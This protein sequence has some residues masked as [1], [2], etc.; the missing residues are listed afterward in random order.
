MK[1]LV[2]ATPTSNAL[3]NIE[4]ELERDPR[5]QSSHSR[6]GYLTDLR[7]FE[8]WRRNRPLTKLLV[9]EYAAHLQ[10]NKRSPNSINR[11][12]ASVRWWARRIADLA[13]DSALPRAQRDEIAGQAAR[14]ASVRD[15]SGQRLPKGRHVAPTELSALLQAC[16]QDAT[17]AG[18]R[19]AAL[20]TL[21]WSTG[22]RRSEICALATGDLKTIKG[23]SQLVVRGK[24]NKTRPAYLHAA[25]QSRLERWLAER[26]PEVGRLFCPVRKG[27]QVASRRGLTAEALAQI[28]AKRARQAGLDQPLTWHDFRRTFAGNLLDGGVDLVTVQKLLGHS[29]PTTTSA[30]DRRGEATRQRAV[31]TLRFTDE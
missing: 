29:S 9:E 21:A 14:V 17:P 30:Y 24:G 6:R 18:R 15:V 23:Q 8:T 12:L 20:I 11:A 28:L 4:A 26:G 7:T 13:L 19:D 25:A 3:A 27:G 5:L 10:K 16:A 31:E 22:L 2:P 1:D